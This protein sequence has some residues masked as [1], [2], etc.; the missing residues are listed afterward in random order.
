MRFKKSLV[1]FILNLILVYSL[2]YI[3]YKR[4]D[5]VQYG[6]GDLEYFEMVKHPINPNPEIVGSKERYRILTPLF[7]T[8][9]DK[10]PVYQTDIAAQLSLED[11]AIFF[12]YL[13]FNYLILALVSAIYFYL[14]HEVYGFS[15]GLSYLGTMLF[16][17]SF[18]I[19]RSGFISID[20]PLTHLFIVLGL[21][22]KKY[23]RFWLFI[24]VIVL[25]VLQKE[26]VILILGLIFFLEFVFQKRS[27]SELKWLVALVLPTLLYIAFVK[28]V[29]IPRLLG[30]AGS[31]GSLLAH[32]L[33]IFD[34]DSYT[35]RFVANTFLGYGSLIACLGLHGL[36]RLKNKVVD[37]PM[38]QLW[39]FP[40]LIFISLA[41]VVDGGNEGRVA[42]Y[43]FP[44]YLI[45]QLS[46]LKTF[47]KTYP[48]YD[49]LSS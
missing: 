32:G 27:F 22:C 2:F 49:M 17:L 35:L 14:A 29:P 47:F 48:A 26:S 10:V 34:P 19:V 46:V 18:H 5:V 12:H 16:L 3:T 4:Y 41:I 23:N 15:S 24:P 13:L 7:V 20:A 28:L 33:R 36:L 39:I 1:V 9:M 43:A 40:V 37:F 6:Q 21:L 45:Y 31:E 38:S 8:L 11:K 30:H 44:V 25:G 42:F